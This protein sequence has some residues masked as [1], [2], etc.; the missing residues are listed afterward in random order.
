VTDVEHEY[1]AENRRL[2]DEIAALR[3]LALR[4]LTELRDAQDTAHGRHAT[5]VDGARRDLAAPSDP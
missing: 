1:A 3:E 2:R 5:W 4:A